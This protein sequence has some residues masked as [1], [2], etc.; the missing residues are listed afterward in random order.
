MTNRALDVLNLSSPSFI[1][2]IGC[3][4]GLSGEILSS[5]DPS[6][7]WIGIDISASM[8]AVAR[9]ERD[10]EGDLFLADMGQGVPFRPGTFDAAIS[11]SAVQW[12]CNAE[13]AEESETPDKRLKRFFNGL[14][15][16]L[17]RGGKA[18]LQ[19]YPKDIK[20]KAMITK[21]AIAAG[22]A[23]GLLEDDE[24]TKN[25]KTYLVCTI[26]GGDIAGVVEGM[27]G[28]DVEDSR[29]GTKK[30]DKV[31]RSH[32]KG[33]K[34]YI[35]RKKGQMEAKGKVVKASSKFTGRKRKTKW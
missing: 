11:I 28:V 10:V 8:L 7:I 24:G 14:Y 22:F 15:V 9:M 27:D 35:N 3:G 29:R 2:D 4:S 1:L 20:Q 31:D 30:V 32:V 6:H 5:A 26:G 12:L 21:A 23:A 34:A 33:T 16:S 13:T 25:A 18:V 17:R 19:F